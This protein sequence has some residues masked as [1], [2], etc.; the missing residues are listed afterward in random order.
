MLREGR[1]GEAERGGETA[2]RRPLINV[3]SRGGLFH[4]AAYFGRRDQIHFIPGVLR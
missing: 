2:L 1:S 4:V 3:T